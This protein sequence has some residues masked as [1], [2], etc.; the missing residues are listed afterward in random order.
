MVNFVNCSH[1]RVRNR[2]I[3]MFNRIANQEPAAWSKRSEKVTAPAKSQPITS[4]HDAISG[5]EKF[6]SDHPRVMLVA[7]FLTGATLAWW[8]KRR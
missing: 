2:E 4:M 6:I 3:G 5:A 1:L 8:L 7:A